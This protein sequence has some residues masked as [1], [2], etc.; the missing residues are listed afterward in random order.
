MKGL[1]ARPSEW[2][3]VIERLLFARRVSGRSLTKYTP[4]FF[5]YNRQPVLPIDIECNLNRTNYG[6]EFEY[7]FNKKTFDTMLSATLSLRQK[8]HQAKTS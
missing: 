2:L 3:Y 5:V 8:T 6:D 7:P 4:F 1:N